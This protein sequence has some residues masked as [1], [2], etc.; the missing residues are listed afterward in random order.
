MDVLGKNG[1]RKIWPLIEEHDYVVI[2][3]ERIQ[4]EGSI[5]PMYHTIGEIGDGDRLM[6]CLEQH[7]RD[8]LEEISTRNSESHVLKT[9]YWCMFVGIEEHCKRCVY[10]GCEV[11]YGCFEEKRKN[12]N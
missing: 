2:E 3:Y 4:Y 7:N 12:K 1:K 5:Q 6:L 8:I 10:V 9:G 11:Y